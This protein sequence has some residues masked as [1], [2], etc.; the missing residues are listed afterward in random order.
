MIAM[1]TPIIVIRNTKRTSGSGWVKKALS[2][3]GFGI[4]RL[5]GD[6]WSKNYALS[7]NNLLK[8]NNENY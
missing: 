6:G 5:A 4:S 2:P 7:H 1:L 8:E 3:S